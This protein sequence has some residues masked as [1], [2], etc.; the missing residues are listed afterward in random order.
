MSAWLG[1]QGDD[2]AAVMSQIRQFNEDNPFEPITMP[3]LLN[4]LRARQQQTQRPGGFGLRLPPAAAALL[5]QSGR[6]ANVE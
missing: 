4:A 6:F 3:G 2:R 1:A 5:A